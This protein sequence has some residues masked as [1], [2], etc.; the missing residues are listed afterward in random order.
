MLHNI[1]EMSDVIGRHLR[2]MYGPHS[3]LLLLC[4][5]SFIDRNVLVLP[6][7]VATEIAEAH[8]KGYYHGLW[9]LATEYE[10]LLAKA[11]ATDVHFGISSRRSSAHGHVNI[12]C[13]C[14]AKHQL[15]VKSFLAML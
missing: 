8:P 15:F 7:E 1:L 12:S 2:E 6:A 3:S 5:F 14:I 10:A 13:L 11:L 9:H 4:D